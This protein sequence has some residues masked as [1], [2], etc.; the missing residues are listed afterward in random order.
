[1]RAIIIDDEANNVDNLTLLLEKYCP[2]VTVVGAASDSDSGI[3]LIARLQPE[4][5]FL[6]IQ[7]PGKS[8][9]EMLQAL[10]KRD[11]E[12]IFVTG[13]DQYGIL[14]I[15][16]AA[17]DY[18]LKP[19]DH[20]ELQAAVERAAIRIGQKKQNAQIEN[21]MQLLADAKPR[22]EHRIALSSA[23]ETR[24]VKT[25]QIVRCAA[26]NNY[27]L[28]F[29]EGGEQLLVSRP[30]FEYDE[31]LSGYGFLRCHNKHL[32]NREF[33]KSLIKEDSGYLLMN[34]GA[35]VPVSRMKK[36]I[37]LAALKGV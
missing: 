17:I 35:K 13:F 28:F 24:L 31:L 18:L 22:A 23:K 16:F 7:M 4:L 9:F 10:P 1:M 15:R 25:S 34:D 3:A 27:T 12:V 5:V 21:L 2:Q 26:E 30:M 20:Q 29:L 33:V 32:V 14:A 11:F 36:E 8:G 19:I 6:D 37:V